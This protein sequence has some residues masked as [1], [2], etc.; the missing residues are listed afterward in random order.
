MTEPFDIEL[1]LLHLGE[2]GIHTLVNLAVWF[3]LSHTITY[4]I[5]IRTFQF[6]TN[7]KAMINPSNI[8]PQSNSSLIINSIKENRRDIVF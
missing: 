2:S 5:G 8:I 4:S 3:E 6:K 1:I 7:E